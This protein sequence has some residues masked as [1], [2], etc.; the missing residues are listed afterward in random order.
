MITPPP[1]DQGDEMNIDMTHTSV[2]ISFEPIRLP[3]FDD[4][5][6]ISKKCQHGQHGL[7]KCMNLLAPDDFDLFETVDDNVEAVMIN[8]RI[9]KRMPK[10]KILELLKLHVFPEIS[11]GD[12]VKVDIDIHKTIQLHLDSER[13]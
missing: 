5:L 9:L 1:L 7:T 12:L 11:P 10:E 4:I 3:P 6:V 8:K 13:N 2:S